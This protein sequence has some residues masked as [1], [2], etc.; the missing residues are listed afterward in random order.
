MTFEAPFIYVLVGESKVLVLD[1]GAIENHLD[2]PLYQ[3]IAA[4]LG[5]GGKEVKEILVVHSHSHS[6]HY[7]GD[8]QFN[9][10]PN[11]TLVKPTGDDVMSFFG[12][13]EWPD[14]EARVELGRR[15]L[16]VIPTPGH[17]EDAITIY[18]PKTKWLLTGDTLYPGY[19]Y[20]KN[21]E[22]YK[23]SIARLSLFSESNDVKALLGSHIEMT[24]EPGKYY[25][26]GT[27]FQPDEAALDLT[28]DNLRKL[29]DK[30]QES[31]EKEELV[32]DR[33]IVA[34]MNVIQRALSNFTR[35]ITQ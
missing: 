22:D 30:L 32:F 5:Q 13:K 7:K 31:N 29:N 16:I 26:I 12:F 18:D 6:D 27:T 10:E 21:W 24:S 8:A 3:T 15:T 25:P 11:V 23:S 14:S 28:L 1:T 9:G 19:I 33:F 2:S 35:W 20:V 34:P 4:V 17:Q